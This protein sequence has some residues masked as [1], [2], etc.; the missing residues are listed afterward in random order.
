M[1][2]VKWSQAIEK[3]DKSAL[4]GMGNDYL[5]MIKNNDGK[6]VEGFWFDTEREAR[7]FYNIVR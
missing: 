6:T 5:V 4:F 1:V 2:T 7:K 3:T